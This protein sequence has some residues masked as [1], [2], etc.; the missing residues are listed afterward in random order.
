MTVDPSVPGA[1]SILGSKPAWKLEA[2][3]IC[4]QLLHFSHA[5][6]ELFTVEV[7]PDLA[8]ASAV[9]G[10]PVTLGHERCCLCLARLS[11][12]LC[13]LLRYMFFFHCLP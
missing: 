3:Q 11:T 4:L 6:T 1:A 8:S 5:C 7:L 10:L 13:S 2:F 9:V 12:D